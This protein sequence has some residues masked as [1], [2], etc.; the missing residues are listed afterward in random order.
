MSDTSDDDSNEISSTVL[1]AV[2]TFLDGK[3]GYNNYIYQIQLVGKKGDNYMGIVYRIKVVSNNKQTTKIILKVPPQNELRRQQFFARPGF[4]REALAYEQFLPLTLDFQKSK[5]LEDLLQFIEYPL[6]HFTL[7]EEYN[8]AICMNDLQDDGFYMHDRFVGLN[9]DQVALVMAIYGKLHGT[10]LALKDQRPE[11]LEIFKNMV[12]IFVQRKNDQQL[13]DYFESLKKSALSCLDTEKDARYWCKL[14]SYFD[15]GSFFDLMLNL[16][17]ATKSEPYS[18][19]CHGDCW[20]NNILFKYEKGKLVDARLLDWQIMRYASPIVDIMYFLMSCT[21]RDFR[22]QHFNEM[23]NIYHAA[24]AKHIERLGSNHEILYPRLGL[25]RELKT[26][27]AIGLLFAMIV[28]PILTTK[29]EDVPDLEK[30]SEKVSAGKSTDAMEAGF[31]GAKSAMFTERMK[32]IVYDTV[33][34]G[35]I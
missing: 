19:V 8:E 24:S 17:D 27:G 34:W 32:E 5:G 2:Q 31:V 22:L 12:D 28:L 33:D 35:L 7:T 13:N 29:S 10:S 14:K 18:V 16:L 9:Y 26:K 21:T 11:R 20:S 25:E 1:T 3:F 30:L 4:L 23:L 15:Q 6:C